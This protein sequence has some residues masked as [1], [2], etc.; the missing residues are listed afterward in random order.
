MRPQ[1]APD[2]DIVLQQFDVGG[3]A[4]HAAERATARGRVKVDVTPEQG[5]RP[6]QCAAEPSSQPPYVSL[7]LTANSSGRGTRNSSIVG[8]S[9]AL[10]SKA[11]AF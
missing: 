10:Y 11:P 5:L 7:N 8:G 9:K 3:A 6:E 4:Q 1:E 2:I